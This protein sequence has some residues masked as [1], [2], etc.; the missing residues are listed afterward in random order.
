MDPRELFF[1][2]LA[3]FCLPKNE[4]FSLLPLKQTL[5]NLTKTLIVVLSNIWT[6]SAQKSKRKSAKIKP[7][8]SIVNDVQGERPSLKDPIAKVRSFTEATV[9][10]T[11][12]KKRHHIIPIIWK[13]KTDSFLQAERYINDKQISTSREILDSLLNLFSMGFIRGCSRMGEA[14]LPKVCHTYPTMMITHL[15]F[16]WSQHFFT[17]N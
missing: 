13:K 8:K 6:R 4:A 10:D 2:L 3:L 16:C 7:K 5:I 17:G 11:E 14:P 12:D 15:E 1:I 9:G